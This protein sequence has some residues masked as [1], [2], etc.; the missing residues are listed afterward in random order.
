ML[1]QEQR[2]RNLFLGRWCA[3]IIC[4][5]FYS[6]GGRLSKNW[7]AEGSFLFW[8]SLICQAAK[9]TNFCYLIFWELRNKGLDSWLLQATLQ[10]RRGSPLSP[11]R[12]SSL[13]HNQAGP[14][15]FFYLKSLLLY[16]YFFRCWLVSVLLRKQRC[17]SA[18]P[19]L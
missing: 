14:Y 12:L 5:L 15:F 7:I 18:C 11:S 9:Q 19:C 8:S 6:L 10:R 17:G 1:G 2:G 4:F 13:P 16:I 3:E